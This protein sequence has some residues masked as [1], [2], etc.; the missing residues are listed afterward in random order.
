[1][2]DDTRLLCSFLVAV[3][4]VAFLVVFW[5]L[6]RLVTVHRRDRQVREGREESF[7]EQ[8]N[9]DGGLN[10]VGRDL[11]CRNMYNAIGKSAPTCGLDLSKF[12]HTTTVRDLNAKSDVNVGRRLH[13][14]DETRSKEP[15]MQAN[16]SDAYYLQKNIHG[17][18]KSTLDLTMNDD[19]DER[20]RIMSKEEEK[21]FFQANGDAGHDGNLRVGKDV[22]ASGNLKADGNLDVRNP[23]GRGNHDGGRFHTFYEGSDTHASLEEY[24]DHVS[25]D[26]K[27]HKN[28]DVARLR[29]DRGGNLDLLNRGGR[30]RL[31]RSGNVQTDKNLDVGG[32]ATMRGAHVDGDIKVD[33]KIRFGPRGNDPYSLEKVTN[34]NDRSHLRLSLND[35][36][37]ES[38]R[39]YTNIW[40]RGGGAKMQHKFQVN[41]DAWHRGKL[42]ADQLCAGGTC[43]GQDELGTSDLK[44]E[45]ERL[46]ERVSANTDKTADLSTKL[47]RRV[48]VLK[49][50]IGEST[51]GREELEKEIQ[52]VE[53][54]LIGTLR[55]NTNTRIKGLEEDMK[56]LSKQKGPK[57]DRGPE[58][59]E[60]DTGPQGPKGDRGPQG[61]G[62]ERGPQGPKGDKGDPATGLND[63]DNVAG[64][65]LNYSHPLGLRSLMQYVTDNKNQNRS[66][67]YRNHAT[68]RYDYVNGASSWNAIRVNSD[69]DNT[70]NID[71]T[72]NGYFKGNVKAGEK[73]CIGNTCIDENDLKNMGSSSGP[74]L[75]AYASIDKDGR[76]ESPSKGYP[77]KNVDNH[78]THNSN[79]FRIRRYGEGKYALEAPHNKPWEYAISVTPGNDRTV[80]LSRYGSKR[81]SNVYVSFRYPGNNNLTDSEF[82][83]LAFKVK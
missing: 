19:A 38:L 5:N 48:E 81:S 32:N 2:A 51:E 82:E 80:R 61:P 71:Q 50:K 11:N 23:G 26:L 13:F 75:Y 22:H 37:D 65:R 78:W 42:M 34:G 54:E 74:E 7:E 73:L 58:G 62:G 83:F 56:G 63:G 21:H 25:Y 29:K 45:F 28:N 41:G 6:R 27:T 44:A 68:T 39:I 70:V 16:N 60:G 66:G 8:K 9:G 30:L 18:N 64:F 43:V 53:D 52:K 79:H 46:K 59:P 36:P 35:N 24:D 57:G 49:G 40:N 33:G 20:F 47:Q 31:D 4:V 76:V 1:M 77:A 12:G 69:G 55:E 67:G 15:D 10:D 3:V 17:R 72:G 14:G